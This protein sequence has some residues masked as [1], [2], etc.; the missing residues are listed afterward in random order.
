MK[1]VLFVLITVI[2]LCCSQVF[3]DEGYWPKSYFVEAGYG[4]MISKGDFNEKSFSIRDT[5]DIKGRVHPVGLEMYGTPDLTI[6]ANIAQFTLALNFQYTNTN[7]TLAGFPDDDYTADTRIWRL[8]FEF[9]YNL[10]WPENFQ[11]G[12]GGGYSYTS[13]KADDAIYF[14]EVCSEGVC[15]GD[16]IYSSEMMGSAFGFIAN[17]H[18]YITDNISMVPA[19][20]I[21]E[22]W[23][24]N[25]YSSRT[26]NCDL[27]PYMWQT[28]ILVSLSV[29]YTF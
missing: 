9:T 2:G 8:G 14:G 21:Y 25:V 15:T 20:K 10:F 22:N 3:A 12:L 4:A 5:N 23:F 26:E 19:I 7:Q 16:D 29:Q 18:Y 27:D 17:L 28:F 6:G 11:I 1:K 13:I 24:K